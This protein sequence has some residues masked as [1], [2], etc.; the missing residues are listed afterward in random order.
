MRLT[1]KPGRVAST[2]ITS[3]P[4][5]RAA[6]RDGVVGL[7]GGL[8]GAHDLDEL[9]QRRRV[10][11][12]HADDALGPLGRAGELRDRDDRR[13]RARIAPAS[14]PRRSLAE[15]LRASA[16]RSRVAASTTRSHAREARPSPRRADPA[17]E[18]VLVLAPSSCPCR[19]AC[20]G[21]RQSAS[22][23]GLGEGSRERRR[24]PPRSRRGRDLRDAAAHLS[25]RR[26]RRSRRTGILRPLRRRDSR[27]F[28]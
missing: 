1:R 16:R 12:V 20:R 2:V 25:R 10:H 21:C 4:S 26:A 23:S 22:L 24:G 17:D 7:V 5:S 19:P 15:E 14:S 6:S 3:C 27:T 28:A 11:E 13:V 8:H 9:H 18:R